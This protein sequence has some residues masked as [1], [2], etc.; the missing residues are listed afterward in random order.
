[1]YLTNFNQREIATVKNAIKQENLLSNRGV[2][3]YCYIII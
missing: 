2:C 1:M 3:G